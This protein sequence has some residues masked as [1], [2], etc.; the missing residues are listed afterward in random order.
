MASE[1][2]A[3]I[4]NYCQKHKLK[5]VYNLSLT[6][7]SH[8]PEVTVTI[9]I[10]DVEYGTGTGKNKKEAK[11]V[12]AKKTWEM[13]EKQLESPSDTQF[14]E[15]TT[16]RVTL[17]PVDYVSMLN[18]YSQKE[19]QIVDYP[20]KCIGEA[21]A[22]TY[23]CSCTI[24]GV[25]YG[26][27]TGPSIA[28]AKQA[29][30]KQAY[31]KLH[32]EEPVTAGSEKP[33]SNS[34]FSE[35]SHSSQASAQSDSNNRSIC[36]EDPA[37]KLVEKMKDVAVCDEKTSPSQ[38]GAR[39][40]AQKFQRKLAA[41]F[42][43]SRN[44][45][46][47]IKMADSDK[48]LPDF[49]TNISEENG[50]PYTVNDRFL[51]NFKNIEPIGDG[52]FGNVF[53]ATGKHDEKTYAVKRV[54]FAENVAREVKELAR[55]EHENIVRYYSCWEGCDHMIYPASRQKSHKK[56]HCFFI[57][58]E[59]CEQ[60]PLENWIEKNRQDRKYYYMAQNKF[61]QILRG[62]EYIHSEGLIHRDLKPQNIFISREDKIKIGDF[63]LVT[64]V[65]RETL[66]KDRGTSS[67]M[68]PEQAGDKYGK[69]VDIYA[70]GLIWFEML[71]EF[72]FHEKNQLWPGVKAGQLP[73]SFTNR[74]LAEAPIIKKMLSR[75]PS[76]RYPASEILEFMSR[77]K[78]KSFRNHT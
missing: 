16:T 38:R 11:A 17:L 49:D 56:I 33:N 1:Y 29:A 69:E 76:D 51:E 58:M 48:N 78:D 40:P 7:P 39:S 72:T 46:E 23:S 65:E 37:A 44:K 45:E 42:D 27:G 10:N 47:K 18:T 60:G 53:K 52:G 28:A 54:Q 41:N 20:T 73:E 14:E 12:A 61:L 63:G 3:K 8:D 68:A 6:G 75:E 55:L 70:L 36:F 9:K 67:Y 71:W 19:K 30:A 74:F 34:A 32:K 26:R 59:L 43:N 25:L 57:Q 2:M 62:V 22:R 77:H 64:S 24:S 5:L 13:I 31:E 4:N 35:G 21:H 50:S 15:L 66:T